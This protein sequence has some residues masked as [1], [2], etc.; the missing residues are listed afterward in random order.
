MKSCIEREVREKT[1]EKRVIDYP[2]SYAVVE[3]RRPVRV[4]V[5]NE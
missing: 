1:K 2:I 5:I 4:I 3:K